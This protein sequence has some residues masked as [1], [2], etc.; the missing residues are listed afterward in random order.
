M[1]GAFNSPNEIINSI[2]LIC[3]HDII[4]KMNVSQINLIGKIESS[5]CKILKNY[6]NKRNI[7][8]KTS[9]S[10][11]IKKLHPIIFATL[12]DL[13]KVFLNSTFS[14]KNYSKTK[15]IFINYSNKESPINYWGNLKK[16]IEGDIFDI[17]ID[18]N[19]SFG[20]KNNC[21]SNDFVFSK[22]DFLLFFKFYFSIL[23]NVFRSKQIKYNFNNFLDLK[24]LFK[25]S[26]KRSFFGTTA[27]SNSIYYSFFQRYFRENS[28]VKYVYYPRENQA[29]EKIMLKTVDKNAITIG[30][31]HAALKFWDLRLYYSNTYYPQ[32]FTVFSKKVF[33]FLKERKFLKNENFFHVE[34]LRLKSFNKNTRERKALLVVLDYD[35]EKSIEMIEILENNKILEKNIQ[36]RF[37]PHPSSYER[38]KKTFPK[39]K[40]DRNQLEISISKHSHFFCSNN[41]SLSLEL[42][43]SGL[44][45]AVMNSIDLLDMNPLRIFK[46][47]PK[48][49][50]NSN[51]LSIFLKSNMKDTNS[52]TMISLNKDLKK[53]KNLIS[54]IS[55]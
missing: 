2:K 14:K 48:I 24:P 36:I 39:L 13:F 33:D 43:N 20:L 34:S 49:I 23:K 15:T 19:R 8:L 10:S 54:K 12:N 21:I 28:N 25:L 32:F 6:C 47:K 26:H 7:I 17:N 53:W 42:F 37:R 27:I 5:I 22:I 41:T 1:T 46:V 50:F 45:V 40:Y 44:N 30:N 29:W 18:I 4:D 3:F 11:E 51:D 9:D 35:Y 38:I 55:K 52:K 31:L 16:T